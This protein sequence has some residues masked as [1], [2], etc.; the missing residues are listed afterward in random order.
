MTISRILVLCGN[1]GTVL[2][3]NT[4]TLI[5]NQSACPE[6]GSQKRSA[7]IGIN[8]TMFHTEVRMKARHGEKGKPFH[9]QIV[10]DN[11]FHQTGEWRK[12]EMVFDHANDWYSKVVY[13]SETGEVVYKCGEPLSAHQGHGSAKMK[14]KD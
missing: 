1:C 4:S 8:V 14:K 10:G 6:C 7:S 11:F 5:E 9:E 13:R 12:R 3:E 2:D